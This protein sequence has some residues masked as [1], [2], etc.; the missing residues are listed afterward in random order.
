[1]EPGQFQAIAELQ[2]LQNSTPKI[3]MKYVPVLG[4]VLF[5]IVFL[6]FGLAHFADTQTML[7]SGAVPSFLPMKTVVIYLTGIV[8]VG[9]GVAVLLGYRTK[10]AALALGVMML[11]T[12]FLTW[13]PQLADGGMVEM[14]NFMKDMSLAGAALLISHFGAGPMSMDARSTD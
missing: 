9:G 10:Q 5:S 8:I 12:A 6:V 14:G 7:E 1:M 2:C 3:K 13:M 11:G 4:R